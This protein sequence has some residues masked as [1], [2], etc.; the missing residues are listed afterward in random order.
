MGSIFSPYLKM[1]ILYDQRM[2]SQTV[3]RELDLCT[4]ILHVCKIMV[5]FSLMHF[6]LRVVTKVR[7]TYG[8]LTSNSEYGSVF[9]SFGHMHLPRAILLSF[10][11]NSRSFPKF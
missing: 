10:V 3:L 8:I 1:P 7:K 5:L 11:L 9:W 6:F 4:Q 2:G